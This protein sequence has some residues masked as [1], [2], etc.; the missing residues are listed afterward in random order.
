MTSSNPSLVFGATP[1]PIEGKTKIL[2]P[3][4]TDGEWT[5]TFKDAATAFN[6]QKYAEIPGKGAVN[7]RISAMLFR[8]LESC[9]LSTCF[10][11]EGDR[12][13]I[14]IYRPL[15]MIRLEVVVRNVALGSVVKR[16]S[17]TEGERF[18]RPVVEFFY[19]CQ[20]DPLINDE[21][22][23]AMGLVEQPEQLVEIR[24]LALAANE[25]FVEVFQASGICCADFKLEFGFDAE[26]K[27]VLGD[28]LSPDNFRLRDL[29]SGA[30]LDKDVFRLDLGDVSETYY[31]LLARLETPL[32]PLSSPRKA[33]SETIQDL[34]ASSSP[35]EANNYAV[36][37]CV[38]SR[39]GILNPESRTVLETIKTLGYESPQA[40][41]AQLG[42]GKRFT[43]DVKAV[44]TAAAEAF[45]HRLAEEVLSNPV[46]EEYTVSV[47]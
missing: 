3:T 28:E 31:G 35:L 8:R 36:E 37:I 14:L 34:V 38:H 39:Q 42:V 44:N 16:Y 24:R 27:L 25:V 17:L 33:F 30:V 2:Q 9:G 5:V 22:A 15:R 47:H 21:L 7:A 26:G 20:D 12:P 46:I 10:V 40:Q 32:S 19:K 11:R 13:N 43:L 4:T 29:K 23:L 1:K 45:A 6:G 41:L 18:N